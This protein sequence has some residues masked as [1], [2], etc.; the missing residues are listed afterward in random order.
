MEDTFERQVS[1]VRKSCLCSLV[2]SNKY[3]L[4]NII[5]ILCKELMNSVFHLYDWLF[6]RIES[7]FSAY[8]DLLIKGEQNPDFYP[9]E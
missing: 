3:E 7:F 1:S 9:Q 4:C 8:Q 5:E 6:E 2:I